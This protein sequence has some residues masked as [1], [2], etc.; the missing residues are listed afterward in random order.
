MTCRHEHCGQRIIRCSHPLIT[1]RCFGWAHALTALHQCLSG[2]TIAE[3]A[4]AERSS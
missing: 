3:P 2:G 4:E 1:S